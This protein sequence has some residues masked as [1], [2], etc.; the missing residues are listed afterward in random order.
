MEVETVSLDLLLI[1]RLLPKGQVKLANA[2]NQELRLQHLIE[3]MHLELPLDVLHRRVK[4]RALNTPSKI[5]W[6]STN[7][8]MS[9]KLVHQTEMHKLLS[10]LTAVALY[11]YQRTPLWQLQLILINLLVIE[12]L[13]ITVTQLLTVLEQIENQWILLEV[14][15]IKII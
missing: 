2:I 3:L 9:N 7:L 14:S 5:W 15:A 1:L 12:I 10:L 8:V 4:K 11:E 6:N 13:L